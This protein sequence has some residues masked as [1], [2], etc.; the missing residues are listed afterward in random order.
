M[1][2]IELRHPA[3]INSMPTKPQS[4][5]LLL[6]LWHLEAARARTPTSTPALLTVAYLQAQF[7]NI[8]HLRML[9]T[10]AFVD[11]RAWQLDI[12][13]GT[14]F[15][16]HPDMRS[17]RNRSQGPFWLMPGVFE[18]MRVQL[19]G[20]AASVTQVRDYLQI[21]NNVAAQQPLTAASA[22]AANSKSA[23]ASAEFWRAFA[24]AKREQQ[25]GHL[26]VDGQQGALAGYRLTERLA[27]HPRQTAFALLQQAMVWRRA[28][29]PDAALAVLKQL[30]TQTKRFEDGQWISAMAMIVQA[31]CAY[32]HRDVRAAARILLKAEQDRQLSAA[33]AHHPRV[34]AERANL[35]ALLYRAAA[36]DS[37]RSIAERERSADQALDHYHQALDLASEAELFDAAA[38][39]ASNLG[40]SI[41]L[42]VRCKLAIVTVKVASAE[43]RN[44]P[45]K[46]PSN[47]AQQQAMR[48]IALAN[49]LSEQHGSSGGFWNQIYLL[50]VARDGGIQKKPASLAVFQQWPV[51]SFEEYTQ[52]YAPQTSGTR[53]RSWLQIVRALHTEVELGSLQV[54]ALQRC[55]VLLELAWYEA[56]DD[57][58]KAARA[59]VARLQKRLP[60]LV[61]TD[62]AFFRQALRGLPI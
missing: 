56:Y 2:T 1:I 20:K 16:V 8:K 53:G 13:W 35:K 41:W 10:R 24:I 6:A 14:D 7:P 23:Q 15:S 12:G 43:A 42:F 46:T 28:G 25:D 31:W 52:Q 29:N 4:L 17:T 54:D 32:A 22:I 44:S 40:W 61:V 50:R 49:L 39:A 11:F 48:W 60:E 27:H 5:W 59:A 37:Q 55:N 51:L 47:D 9:I 19:N 34:Q 21:R 58:V 38:S 57:E 62:R 26:I 45:S 33:F 36:L 3:S 18:A 30:P